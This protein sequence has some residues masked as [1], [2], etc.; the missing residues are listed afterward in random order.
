MRDSGRDVRI[1][2]KVFVTDG[3]NALRTLF[4]RCWFDQERCAD[5]INALRR[6]R[7]GVNP[8]TN[9]WTKEPLHDVNSHAADALRYFAT[10]M[11]EGDSG[12][13]KPLKADIG[14]V[15]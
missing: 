15:V 6:Y 13:S 9:Q 2:P 1:V 3:I 5:G 14:W 11:Q 4:P 7:Y 8:E 12:W 10:A